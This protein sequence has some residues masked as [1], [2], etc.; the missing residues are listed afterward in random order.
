MRFKLKHN[1]LGYINDLDDIDN[2]TSLESQAKSFTLEQIES[3]LQTRELARDH[4]TVIR[5]A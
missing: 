3:F 5:S 2:T 4:Y 1:W